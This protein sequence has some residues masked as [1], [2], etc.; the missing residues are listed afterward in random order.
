MALLAV[1]RLLGPTCSGVDR[2]EGNKM[3]PEL[4][5]HERWCIAVHSHM[6]PEAPFPWPSTDI[7]KP[8]YPREWVQMVVNIVTIMGLKGS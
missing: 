3:T 4:T 1:L 2:I 7:T 6:L 8:M 5:K